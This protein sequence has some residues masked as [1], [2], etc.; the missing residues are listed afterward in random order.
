MTGNKPMDL[1]E[2]VREAHHFFICDGRGQVVDARNSAELL[3][4]D[5]EGHPPLPGK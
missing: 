2:A 3:Y 4:H 5:V 1:E